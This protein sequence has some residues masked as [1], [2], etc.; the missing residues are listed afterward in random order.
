MAEASN[1]SAVSHL[2]PE[3]HVHILASGP[4]WGVS[5][6]KDLFAK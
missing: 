4:R 2:L 1:R 3:F 5:L 6:A